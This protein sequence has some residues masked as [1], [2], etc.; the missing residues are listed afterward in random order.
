MVGYLAARAIAGVESVSEGIYRRT[1]A[2]EGD[3]GVLELF[4]GGH[5]YLVLRAHLPHW[6]GLIH[7]VRGVE[8]AEK[9]ER[10]VRSWRSRA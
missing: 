1:V 8:T 3:P 10:W 5:D 4:P 2:I 9:R 6:E 7:T